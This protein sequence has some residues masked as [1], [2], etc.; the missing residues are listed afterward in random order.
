[1]D[2]TITTVFLRLLKVNIRTYSQ[3]VTLTSVLEVGPRLTV[4][5]GNLSKGTVVLLYIQDSS[6]PVTVSV[7]VE[8]TSGVTTSSHLVAGTDTVCD[9]RSYWGNRGLVLTDAVTTGDSVFSLHNDSVSFP[10][11]IYLLEF[12]VS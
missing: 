11:V 5:A 12:K 10:S 9:N 8:V 1:M 7:E 4:Y 3:K 2:K 6:R